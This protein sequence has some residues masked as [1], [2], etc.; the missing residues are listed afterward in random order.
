MLGRLEF[1]TLIVWMKI[2]III[3]IYYP[4]FLLDFMIMKVFIIF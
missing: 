2:I 1:G 3:I 4:R